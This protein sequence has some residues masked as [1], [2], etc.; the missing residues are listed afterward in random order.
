M[1][2]T[3]VFN[4]VLALPGTCVV[5]VR[6]EGDAVVVSVRRRRQRMVCPCGATTTA[7]YDRGV[8]RWRHLDACGMRVLLEAQL[9][10]IDCRACGRV[11]T[12]L[13][14]WARPWC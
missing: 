8:R 7:V 4:R 14:P 2:V 5:G 3:S 10:R 1:R 13:V 12:E 9:S 11:R 6:V